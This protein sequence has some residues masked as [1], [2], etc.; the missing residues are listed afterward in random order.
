MNIIKTLKGAALSLLMIAGLAPGV[1]WSAVGPVDADGYTWTDSVP[2]M[3]M[4]PHTFVSIVGTGVL[5]PGVN[6]CDDCVSAALPIGFPIRYR[7]IAYTSVYVST[8]GVLSFSPTLTSQFTTDP[9]IPFVGGAGDNLLAPLFVDLTA[10]AGG[11][12]TSQLKGVAPNREFIVEYNVVPFF[13]G[14]GLNTFQVVLKEATGQIEFRYQNVTTKF[15]PAGGFGGSNAS[16][17]VGIE[18]A[19]GTVG[20]KY[21]PM[22]NVNGVVTNRTVRF[23]P[24]TGLGGFINTVVVATEST[25]IIKQN[26]ATSGMLAFGSTTLWNFGTTVNLQVNNAT[27][28]GAPATVTA[29]ATGVDLG[30]GLGIAAPG[31]LVAPNLYQWT[32]LTGAPIGTVTRFNLN[33]I[34]GT[35][36]TATAGPVTYTVTI[37]QPGAVGGAAIEGTPLTTGPA[38]NVIPALTATGL[39]NANTVADVGQ[40]VAGVP[41]VFVAPP[42]AAGTTLGAAGSNLTITNVTTAEPMLQNNLVV[43]LLGDFSGVAAIRATGMTASSAAGVPTAGA[44]ANTMTIT[45]VPPA[46][47]GVATAVITGGLAAN[48]AFAFSPRLVFDGVT[49]QTVRSFTVA[50]D[51]LAGGSYVAAPNNLASASIVSVSN[52]GMKFSTDLMGTASSNKV[53]IRDL[54]NNLPPAGGRIMI[55]GKVFPSLA[56]G[57]QA[58]TPF[59]PITLAPRL[60]SGGQVSLTPAMIA[61]DPNVIAAGGLPAGAA[62]TFNFTVETA[63]GTASEKKQVA[64]VGINAQ[65]ILVSPT[66]STTGTLF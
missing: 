6:G 21:A 23:A 50:V 13:S 19:T 29:Q 65:T 5:V 41:Y 42:A 14:A 47:T 7:G 16:T 25:P 24:L 38:F 49:Q 46:V 26:Q 20:V 55:S 40:L 31:T 35:N 28:S 34:Q 62:A 39:V 1:A 53:V 11:T 8:N 18:N 9:T 12:I 61:A 64:G 22:S 45:Q 32:L 51:I 63:S 48:S 52:N 4:V 15:S 43:K 56:P 66:P 54:S 37:N 3:P 33:T 10:R 30:A 58:G 60:L 36:L 17:L 27:F 59:G 44:P 57:A 2:P